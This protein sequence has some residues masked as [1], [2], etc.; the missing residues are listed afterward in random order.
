M[1]WLKRINDGTSNGGEVQLDEECAKVFA[2]DTD[3][4]GFDFHD[5]PFSGQPKFGE[6]DYQQ[7]RKAYPHMHVPLKIGPKSMRRRSSQQATPTSTP[8]GTPKE[9]VTESPTL[10]LPVPTATPLSSTLSKQEESD[11][12]KAAYTRRKSPGS[13]ILPEE[14]DTD[15]GNSSQSECVLSD[16]YAYF[17]DDSGL[18][19]ERKVSFLNIEGHDKFDPNDAGSKDKKKR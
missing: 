7:H 4:P 14:A 15:D 19:P 18:S 2:M 11:T 1:Y 3:V 6:K 16:P 5:T 13:V 17:E 8:V 12:G 10:E 9:S